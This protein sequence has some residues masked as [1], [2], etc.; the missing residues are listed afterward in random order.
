MDVNGEVGKWMELAWAIAREAEGKEIGQSVG[1]VVVERRDGNGRAVAVAGD[2][3]WAG[4]EWCRGIGSGN[5]TAHAAMRVI[6]MVAKGLAD[7]DGDESLG[8]EKEVD[9]AV[10]G[11]ILESSNLSS[12]DSTTAQIMSETEEHQPSL[13]FP[14]SSAKAVEEGATHPP[15]FN[16]EIFQDNPL[17]SLEHEHHSSSPPTNGYL[18]HDLEIYLTHEPCVMCSMAIIHSRFGRIVF[19][20]RMSQTGGLCADEKSELGLGLFWKKELNWTALAWE[21]RRSNRDEMDGRTEILEVSSNGLDL[22]HA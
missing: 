15:S 11:E 13:R 14:N 22:M 7:R 10:V 5:V 1:A 12:K 4:E 9:A 6:G 19:E 8:V 20:K 17:L 2:G 21:F 18:C 16:L 3:R